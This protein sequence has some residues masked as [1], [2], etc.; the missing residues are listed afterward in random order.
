M[1]KLSFSHCCLNPSPPHLSHVKAPGAQLQDF[2]GPRAGAWCPLPPACEKV[3]EAPGFHWQRPPAEGRAAPHLCRG[4]GPDSHCCCASWGWWTAKA[5]PL[6]RTGTRLSSSCGRR[7]ECRNLLIAD[8][9][10]SNHS[11]SV[12]PS[13]SQK[14]SWLPLRGYHP[15]GLTRRGWLGQERGLSGRSAG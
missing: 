5:F 14:R 6:I 7:V 9:W 13:L 8:G 15:Q 3:G 4:H 1:L 12:L 2:S 10:V 11:P